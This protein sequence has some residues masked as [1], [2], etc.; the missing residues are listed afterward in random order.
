MLSL[1]TF[2][3][4]IT[5]KYVTIYWIRLVEIYGIKLK[6]IGKGKYLIILMQ[7]N[8]NDVFTDKK[9]LLVGVLNP[10]SS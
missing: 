6:C 3:N 7:Q 2:H 9:Q 4:I 10:N 1:L 8:F 5:H